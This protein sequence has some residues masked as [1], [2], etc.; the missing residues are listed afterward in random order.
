MRG[1]EADDGLPV[2]LFGNSRGT[3]AT[4]WAMTKNF[5]KDCTL[6]LPEITCGPPV[7][8]RTIKGAILFSEFTSGQGYVMDRPSIEDEERGLGRDRPALHRRQRG[9][10]QP[11][12]LSELGHPRG[13]GQV[14][15][16]ILRARPVRLR[17]VAAGDRRQLR[18]REGTEGAR[19]GA[20]AAPVRVVAAR[21]SSSASRNGRSPSR[22]ALIQ[23][24]SRVEGGRPWTNMKELAATASDVWEASTK[25]TIVP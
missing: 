17:R 21:R 18:P 16:G 10:E 15:R 9:R 8:D 1:G 20:R 3:M 22:V 2:I 4:G 6:D 7:G 24:K 14:A 5:D 19:R 12:L 13:H 23:G 11:H 25:P